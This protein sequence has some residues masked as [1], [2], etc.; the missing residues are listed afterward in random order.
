MM[1]INYKEEEKIRLDKYLCK[2]YPDIS[3]SKIQK[4]IKDEKILVN[5]KKTTVHHFLKPGDE[6]EI[7]TNLKN[8]TKEKNID[9]LPNKNIKLNIISETKDYL[10]INKPAGVL[11]HPTDKNE[12]DTL[13]NGL[14]NYLPSI[15][16]IGDSSFRPGIVHRIDRDVSGILVV[17]KTQKMFDFLKQQFKNRTIKKEYIVLVYGKMDDQSGIIDFP[18]GINKNSGKM[19]A[20]PKSTEIES[21]SAITLYEVKKQFQHYALLKILIKTGRTHQIRV[22]LNA[23][24]HP[25]VG[26]QI[27]KPKNLK[28]RIKLNRIFLH[29]QTLEF[30]DLDKKRQ[31]FSCDMP[32]TLKNFLQNLS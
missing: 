22:H 29:A 26:D 19:A 10:I 11:V 12:T 7:K 18:I 23:F 30:N 15:Q 8:D 27:Y 25:I 28:T 24:G 3:R 13:V 32:E 2:K 21:K 5:G 20:R 16:N 4:A 9:I 17:A 31:K 1:L 6:I 14:L